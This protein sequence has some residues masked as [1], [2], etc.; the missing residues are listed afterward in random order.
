MGCR[1]DTI[2]AL[3]FAAVDRRARISDALRV[4]TSKQNERY[5]EEKVGVRHG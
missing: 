2:T 4:A 1:I 3:G 5:E